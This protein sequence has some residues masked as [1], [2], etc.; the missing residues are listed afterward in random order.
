M[1][2]VALILLLSITGCS[3]HQGPPEALPD[4]VKRF[5]ERR[6]NCDYF[7]GEL[8][9]PRDTVRMTEVISGIG[10]FCTGTDRSLAA[11]K[12]KYSGR[13]EIADRLSKYDEILETTKEASGGF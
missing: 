4:D 2:A 3:S 10:R 8:P 12:R 7:R 13:S 11:L 9:D 6:D 1:R 5:I